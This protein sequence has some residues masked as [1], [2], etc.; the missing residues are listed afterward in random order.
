MHRNHLIGCGFGIAL[1]LVVVALAGGSAG[2]LGVLVAALLCPLL[3]LGALA[4]LA[5]SERPAPNPP[6]DE[7][8]VDLPELTQR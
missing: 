1:A 6:S 4:L 2:S 5:R 7:G 3:L 8:T